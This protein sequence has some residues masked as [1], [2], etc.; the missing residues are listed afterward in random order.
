MCDNLKQRD[1]AMK[2]GVGPKVIFHESRKVGV[3]HG[4]RT[5]REEITF[6]ARLKIHSHSHIFRDGQSIHI[7]SATSAQIFR[8][9]WFMPSLGIRVLTKNR[10]S[11]KGQ[12]IWNVLLVSSHSVL[13][14]IWIKG[15]YLSQW[16]PQSERGPPKESKSQWIEIL[17]GG[18]R[19][20]LWFLKHNFSLF[21]L[22]NCKK[23]DA[24]KKCFMS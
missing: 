4:L 17:H 20:I 21:F 7:L 9:L 22:Q 2:C 23:L 18:S 12:F 19:F 15:S 3:S 10:V 1:N 13:E 24:K 16:L 11:S 14:W 6:T 5:P 8:L